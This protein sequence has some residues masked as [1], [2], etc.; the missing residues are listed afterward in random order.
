MTRRGMNRRSFLKLPVLLP[1][2]SFDSPFR[3]EEHCFQYEG[4]IGTS[5]DLV[6]WTKDSGAAEYACQTVLDEIDRLAA[7]LDTRNPIS[8]I[9]QLENSGQR[10]VSHDLFEVLRAY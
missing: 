9:N 2:T 3:S 6:V 10:D 1:L 8:E 7:I 5:L 4:V